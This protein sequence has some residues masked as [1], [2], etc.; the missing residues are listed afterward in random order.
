[1]PNTLIRSA[2]LHST[3][4]GS[5]KVYNVYLAELPDAKGYIVNFENGKRG[6][7]LTPG[8][9]T[10]SPVSLEKA[11]AIFEK[12]VKEK[13]NGSSHY[14]PIDGG[15][16]ASAQLGEVGVRKEADYA[17]MLPRLAGY[18]VKNIAH[19]L[20]DDGWGAQQKFDGERVMVLSDKGAISGI[21][22]TGYVRALPSH[23]EEAMPRHARTTLIDG[24]LVGD[25]YYV[26]DALF[27]DGRD[28]RDQPYD[29][30][31]QQAKRLVS[32]IGH[33]KIHIV[34]TAFDITS[35]KALLARVQ[36]R[37]AE[38]M[39]FWRLDAPYA[40]GESDAVEK[41]KPYAGSSVIVHAHKP[42]KRSVVTAAYKAGVYTVLG[43]VTIPT[44]KP[45]PPVGSVIECN[46]LY[47]H[48]GTFALFQPEFEKVRTDQLPEAC[49]V[50][51]FKMKPPNEALDFT[52]TAEDE[53]ATPHP[54]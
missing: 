2:R 51:K 39:V 12:L 23:I 52:E 44:S 27:V 49:Q 34:V 8:T 36:A 38:G 4:A 53:Y 42:D 30:R 6:S 25:N 35:K 43:A 32:T 19:R 24:E 33:D 28:L 13:V 48:E 11:T 18:E 29:E 21:Q 16:T 14:K 47:A 22:K 3:H 17:P 54:A 31:Y 10:L 5:D 15:N 40:E 9:K 50:E 1:M 26:F 37:G 20:T 45:M 41:F 46:Y 7:T